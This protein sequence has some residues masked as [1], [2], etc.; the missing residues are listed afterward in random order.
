M[1]PRAKALGLVLVAGAMTLGAFGLHALLFS[2]AKNHS[3]PPPRGGHPASPAHPPALQSQISDLSAGPAAQPFIL[4]AGV[5]DRARAEHC[6]A[7]AVYYEAG[8]QGE[9][10]EAAVA[11][12]VLN[13]LRHPDFPKSICG[14][15]YQGALLST[16]CQYSFTCNGALTRS[17]DDGGWRQA[18]RVAR[19]A[20]D[21]FVEPH[22]G[23]A[24]HY[25][26][27]YVSP[28]WRGSLVRVSQIGAHIFYRWP[29][30][31]GA[32]AA[33]FGRYQGHEEVVSRSVLTE[34]DPPALLAIAEAPAKPKQIALKL[35]STPQTYSLNEPGHAPLPGDLTPSRPHPTASQ[36]AQ[37]EALFANAK[38]DSPTDHEAA[39]P[40]PE[41]EP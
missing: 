37:I 3:K 16:G 14:V 6:L 9:L 33:F 27:A 36:L 31:A 29:G 18:V 39:P 12:T 38:T 26:A 41:K 1:K 11:Q 35:G 4:H 23:W 34:G 20:L 5:A 10:G 2:A 40:S 22:V 8:D 21:G 19:Q 13:R 7:Q 15:I 32:P 24:T 30:L 17:P 28:Y 25:H